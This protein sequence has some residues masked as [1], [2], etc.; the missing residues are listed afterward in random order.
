M[1]TT[2]GFHGN[3]RRASMTTQDLAGTKLFTS[4][5]NAV[6]LQQ[7]YA[8]FT[9]G[10]SDAAV[11]FATPDFIMHVPG[12]GGNAGE[13]WGHDGLRTFMNNILAYNGGTFRMHVP[14]IAVDDHTAFTREVVVLNRKHDPA[15]LWTL[16]FMMHY[17]FKNGAIS[18]AW[19][20]PEDQYVYDA[21][22]N[23]RSSAGTNDSVQEIDSITPHSLAELEG[24]PSSAAK[25]SRR[26]ILQSFLERRYGWHAATCGR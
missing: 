23:P 21:Y 6:V 14:A 15:R 2:F 9:A 20:I 25:E 1:A 4:A 10:K 18:E 19:T 13:Y 3:I 17:E 24:A 7:F 11:Q 12:T 26:H 5:A 22:W 8:A 16:R